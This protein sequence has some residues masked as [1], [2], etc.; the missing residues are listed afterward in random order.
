MTMAVTAAV[1]G[2]VSCSNGDDPENAIKGSGKKY[3]IDYTNEG[4][5]LYRAYS[6]TAFKHAGACVQIDFENVNTKTVR[7]GVMG[8]IFDLVE[9]KGVKSFNVIGLRTSDT[10]GGLEYYVSRFTNVTDIRAQN[11]GAP[12]DDYE[13]NGATEKPILSAWQKGKGIKDSENNTVTVYPYAILKQNGSKYQYECYLLTNKI[14][15]LDSDGNPINEDGN[16]VDLSTETPVVIETNYTELTEKKLAVYANIYA[17]S[18]EKGKE[19]CGTLKGKWT[20]RGDY[21]EVGVDED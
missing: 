18:D 17:K 20:Y 1:I 13:G 6:N 11:F 21:K 2:L 15:T 3:S 14:K 19:R 4:S 16:K 10:E 5:K 8:I 9:E 12:E 7:A